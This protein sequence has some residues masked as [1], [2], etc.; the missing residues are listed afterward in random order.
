MTNAAHSRPCLSALLSHFADSAKVGAPNW[1]W[2]GNSAA[3]ASMSAYGRC[4]D[5]IGYGC[6][7]P[8]RTH[9]VDPYQVRTGQDGGGDGCQRRIS[10][11]PDRHVHSLIERQT[12]FCPET[13]CGRRPRA[14]AVPGCSTLRDP[15]ATSNSG[16]RLCQSRIPGREQSA[17][18][19]FPPPVL[20]A[21]AAA[22]PA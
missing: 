12:E 22:T 19:R 5:G 16:R 9:V 17:P 4:Q 13:P 14:A 2:Q 18:A 6:C 3:F 1:F 10:P 11:A 8:G 7:L 21:A 20:A 15:Q